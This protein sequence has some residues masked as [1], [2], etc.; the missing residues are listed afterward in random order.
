MI[1]IR[2]YQPTDSTAL[3]PLAQALYQAMY[4]LDAATGN[5][6]FPGYLQQLIARHGND[7]GGL[8]VA[9][10]EERLLG[11]VSISGLIRPTGLEQTAPSHVY[12]SD[13]YVDPGNRR[14]GIGRQ[15]VEQAELYAHKQGAVHIT[16]RI[17]AENTAAR[18]FY[19]SLAYQ[20]QFMV[21]SKQ[22][23]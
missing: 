11:F 21:A 2:S 13:L 12:L 17:L 15:L 19:H 9:E 3:E 4:P 10:D 14:C 7:G 23:G 1:I 22:L 18:E 16:L 20:D 6:G 8:F 5:T